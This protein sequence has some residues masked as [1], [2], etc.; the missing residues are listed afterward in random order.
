[1]GLIPGIVKVGEG[2]GKKE[3]ACS[4]AQAI[5]P[6]VA[7][8]AVTSAQLFPSAS[9]VIFWMSR[10]LDDCQLPWHVNCF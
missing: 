8:F 9:S 7:F 3:G 10:D 4:S 6:R 1:M 5:F 2:N